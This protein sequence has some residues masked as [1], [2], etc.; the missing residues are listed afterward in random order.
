[1]SLSKKDY[2]KLAGVIQSGLDYAARGAGN[3]DRRYKKEAV[4]F[5][6]QELVKVLA[7]D[8]PRFNKDLFLVACGQ[9]INDIPIVASA[10]P[11]VAAFIDPNG[12]LQ[13]AGLLI[14]R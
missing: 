6:A 14:V 9:G 2:V 8:N 3:F 10:S 11:E 12:S 4:Q 7:T 5:V 13:K 1:M